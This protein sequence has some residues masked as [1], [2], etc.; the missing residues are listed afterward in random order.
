MNGFIVI[1]KAA[2][3]TSH[4]VVNRM[5]RI[6][7]QKKAGHTGTLDPFATGVLPIALGEATKAIQFLDESVKEYEA[8]IGFGR[9]TDTQDCT[10]AT[11]S[12]GNWR[13]LD[14]EKVEALIVSFI[15]PQDQLPPMYSALKHHGTPLYR[16]ARSGV[17]VERATRRVTVYSASVEDIFL[18]DVRVT[19]AC[20]PGTY[21]RT[22]A[23]DMGEKAGCGATL[24]SLRRI[25]T[26]PF[27]IDQAISLEE[28]DRLCSTGA[29]TG[30]VIDPLSALG[31][32]TELRLTERG[33]AAVKNGAIPAAG[34]MISLSSVPP[35]P[36]DR[37]KLTTLGRLAAVAEIMSYDSENLSNSMRFLRVFN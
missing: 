19:F 24:N 16:L 21:I 20:S 37:V 11:L 5:R 28:A 29:L 7:G 35:I 15:G 23:H 4:D 14:P 30:K 32:L 3:M 31:N 12:E 36:G 6:T 33:A 22:L 34:E 27:S 8:V 1:D 13:V 25:R 18:P 10:G 17:V 2:G 9:V 26:G